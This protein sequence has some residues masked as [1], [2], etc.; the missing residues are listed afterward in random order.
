M[1]IGQSPTCVNV[2]SKL[3]SV[4]AVPSSRSGSATCGPGSGGSSLDAANARLS[5]LW[6]QAFSGTVALIVAVAEPFGAMPPGTTTGQKTRLVITAGPTGS[7]LPNAGKNR[8]PCG[9][10]SFTL[11]PSASATQVAGGTKTS[12]S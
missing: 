8:H 1:V 6:L 7:G 9:G 12:W 11:S 5:R 10:T 2:T 4:S 3:S